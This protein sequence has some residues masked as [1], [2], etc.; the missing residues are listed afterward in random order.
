MNL[1]TSHRVTSHH[2]ARRKQW[3][4]DQAGMERW[5]PLARRLSMSLGVGP[6]RSKDPAEQKTLQDV[7]LGFMKVNYHFSTVSDKSSSDG[8]SSGSV[9]GNVP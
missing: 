4:Q 2:A 8:N 6:L 1:I 7:F 3:E 9:N 5:L